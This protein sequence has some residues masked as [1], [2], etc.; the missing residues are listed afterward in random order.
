M[1]HSASLG[2]YWNA[3]GLPRDVSVVALSWPVGLRRYAS[4]VG[5]AHTAGLMDGLGSVL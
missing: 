1:G 5:Y 4:S 2:R 3:V